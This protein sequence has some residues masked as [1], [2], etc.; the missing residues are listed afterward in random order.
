MRA[1]A[2]IKENRHGRIMLEANL[3]GAGRLHC[4]KILALLATT[5]RADYTEITYGSHNPAFLTRVKYYRGRMT[6]ITRTTGGSL[7][8]NLGE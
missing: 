5:L 3:S 8:D 4:D 1:Y 6:L 2:T 7:I